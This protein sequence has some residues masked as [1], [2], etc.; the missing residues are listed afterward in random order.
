MEIIIN[1][2]GI[3]DSFRPNQGIC[4]IKKSGFTDISIDLDKTFRLKSKQTK[5]DIFI[6]Y[7]ENRNTFKSFYRPLTDAVK[8]KNISVYTVKS[9]MIPLDTKYE[10]INESQRLMAEETMCVAKEIGSRYVIVP[11]VFTGVSKK[12][13]WGV[14]KKYYLS[15]VQVARKNG[16]NI[17]IENQCRY[18]NGQLMRG[19]FTDEYETAKQIDELNTNAGVDIFGI[20]MNTVNCNICGMNMNNFAVVL[21]KRVKAVIIS[22]CNGQNETHLFPFSSINHGCQ[23]DWLSLIRGLREAEFDGGLILDISDTAAAFPPILRPQLLSLAKSLADYFKW[24]IEIESLLKKYDRIVLFG[25]GN[26]CRNYMKCYGEKYPPLFT[27]DNNSKT[28]GTIFC[29]LEVKNPEELKNISDDCAIFICNIYYREVEKQIRDMGITNPV[30][31]FNDEYMPS[32]Y[33]DR[34]EGV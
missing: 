3:T 25:A 29:G 28:W 4:D 6:E 23:T 31:Y 14:N 17:L 8:S 13:L 26:M 1:V 19:M 2:S 21:G 27:C 24:Q 22:D 33:Y 34:L 15:L 12:D 7:P 11:P 9:P 18:N 32:F 16:I 10:N 20:C 5:E 30:E